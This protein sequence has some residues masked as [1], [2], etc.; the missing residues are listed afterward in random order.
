MSKKLKQKIGKWLSILN[1]VYKSI[2]QVFFQSF[3]PLLS[4]Q[5]FP[6]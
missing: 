4:D 1:I 2:N 5:P 6:W 3:P